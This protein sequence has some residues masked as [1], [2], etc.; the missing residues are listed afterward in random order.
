MFSMAAY[1]TLWGLQ[2]KVVLTFGVLG[3]CDHQAHG[4][5]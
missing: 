3:V 2:Q 5:E 4:K 1:K